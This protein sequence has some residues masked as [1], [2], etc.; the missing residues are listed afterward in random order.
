MSYQLDA[1]DQHIEQAAVALL[2]EVGDQFTMADLAARAQL[3]R[4]TLYRRIGSKEALLQQIAQRA[5]ADVLL[6][7]DMRTRMLQAARVVFGREGP[8][9]ATMEQIAAEAGIGVATIYRHFGDKM[10]LIQAFV[11]ELTPRGV[12]HE[13][14]LHPT[15][16]VTADLLGMAQLIVPYFYE[17]RDL[18][19]LTLAGNTSDQLFTEQIRARSG[20]TVHKLANYFAAQMA[21]GRVRTADPQEVALAFMGLIFAFT[22]IGP[23]N[24]Q[25]PI[26]NPSQTAQFVVQLFLNGMGVVNSD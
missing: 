10:S 13:L 20:R 23:T 14:A 12:V 22:L 6:Q 17:N 25:T 24:Y 5:D 11:E 19:R 7:P 4:A 15:A 2:Q 3:S 8:A 18:M 16:D 9:A 21:A 26:T 1:T